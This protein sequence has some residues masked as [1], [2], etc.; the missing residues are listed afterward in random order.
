MGKRVQTFVLVLVLFLWG[1]LQAETYFKRFRI[2]EGKGH[3]E[4][5]CDSTQLTNPPMCAHYD[6]FWVPHTYEIE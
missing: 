4:I 6:S 2:I 1:Y 3:W 5:Y